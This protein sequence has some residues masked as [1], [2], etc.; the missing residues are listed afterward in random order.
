MP[1]AGARLVHA[2]GCQPKSTPP[3][4]N[5]TTPSAQ[6]RKDVEGE[7]R[8]DGMVTVPVTANGVD[9]IKL[10]E[11]EKPA[12]LHI[13]AGDLETGAVAG[14]G[15]GGVPAGDRWGASYWSQIRILFQRSIRTRRFEVRSDGVVGSRWGGAPPGLLYAQ[16]WDGTAAHLIARWGLWRPWRPNLF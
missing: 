15:Q 1:P 13:S 11:G 2:R 9:P 10:T 3:P 7:E 14:D 6:L 8:G 4:P 16:S 5:T 12:A